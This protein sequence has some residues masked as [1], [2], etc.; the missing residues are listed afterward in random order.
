MTLMLVPVVIYTLRL[1]LMIKLKLN[2]PQIQMHI[3]GMLSDLM[4]S[5]LYLSTPFAMSKSQIVR[6]KVIIRTNY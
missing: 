5:G 6:Q 4:P 3:R 2:G 1:L